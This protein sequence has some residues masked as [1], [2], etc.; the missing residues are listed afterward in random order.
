MAAVIFFRILEN[1]FIYG[2][3][4]A[5]EPKQ[6]H[7]VCVYSRQ[8]TNSYKIYRCFLFVGMKNAVDIVLR[9]PNGFLQRWHFRITCQLRYVYIYIYICQNKPEDVVKNIDAIKIVPILKY[10]S[11]IP[12]Q[13]GKEWKRTEID[14]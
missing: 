4:T 7:L 3:L 6:I 10:M 2:Y 8:N 1:L 9:E 11:D 5:L 13:W 12:Y 14:N